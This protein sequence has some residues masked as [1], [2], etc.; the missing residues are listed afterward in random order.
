MEIVADAS[1]KL[2]LNPVQSDSLQLR[3]PSFARRNG[4]CSRE[5]SRGDDLA[6]HERRINLIIRE[7]LHEMAQ[8]RERTAEHVLSPAPVDELTIAM[9]RDFERGDILHPAIR[10]PTILRLG[11]ISRAPCKAFA[12]NVS[13][14]VNF[15]FG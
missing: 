12:A 9:K 4:Q 8:R 13:A 7:Q 15:Q 14:G 1:A 11:P 6:S 2:H 3:P 10:A 5:R